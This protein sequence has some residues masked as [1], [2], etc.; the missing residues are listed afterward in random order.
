MWTQKVPF[1]E[2]ETF[3]NGCIK[4]GWTMA[5]LRIIKRRDLGKIR[6]LLSKI[7]VQELDCSWYNDICDE[8]LGALPPK[9]TKLNLSWCNRISPEG[10][11]LIPQEIPSISF[12]HCNQLSETHFKFLSPSIRQLDISHCSSL[13][14]KCFHS[15]QNCIHLTVLNLSGCKH[16]EVG[17]LQY[18]PNSVLDLC[19]D[20]CGKISSQVFDYLPRQLISLSLDNCKISKL[21]KIPGSLLKLHLSNTFVDDK[22]MKYLPDHLRELGICGCRKITDRGVECLPISLV[23]LHLS[24]NDGITSSSINL[25]LKRLPANQTLTIFFDKNTNLFFW[26]CQRGYLHL[27]KLLLTRFQLEHLVNE[28]GGEFI[29]CTP[30]HAAASLGHYAVVEYLLEHGADPSLA[31]PHASTPFMIAVQNGYSDIAEM[32]SRHP[33]VDIR[34]KFENKTPLQWAKMN[35]HQRIVDL[36]EYL[37]YKN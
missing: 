30:L 29:S 19:L 32:L 16:L 9:L 18:L 21:G 26:A 25:L 1:I 35:K 3:V 13:N 12:S 2:L 37:Y 10:I 23:Y 15:L 36:L 22:G 24:S 6:N 34:E 31:Q 11:R 27:T 5:K 4:F 28:F 20:N 17:W 8:E 33:K 14:V 7:E